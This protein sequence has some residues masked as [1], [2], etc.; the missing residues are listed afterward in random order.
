MRTF[1]LIF[2]F[3]IAIVVTSFLYDRVATEKQK[4]DIKQWVSYKRMLY[5]AGGCDKFKEQHGGWPA[6]L[7]ELITALP[8]MN[9]PWC[10][11]GWDRNFG[12]VPY[13][14][15]LGYGKLISYGRDGK[16]GGVGD[17]RDFEIRFPSNTNATWNEQ[18]GFGVRQPEERP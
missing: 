14:N 4:Q 2:G 10:K 13:D 18:E 6:S 17:D 7:R 16:P 12:F 15:H 11:D 9:D 5:I 3:I 1:V 8:E